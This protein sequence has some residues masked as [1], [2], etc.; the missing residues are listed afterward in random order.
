MPIILIV[1][2][3]GDV[4]Q[5]AVK[6]Y[7][8]EKLY[9]KAGFKSHE[10]FQRHHT[11]NVKLNDI[12]YNVSL[13]GKTTGA[14]RSENKYD[15]PPPVDNLLFFS[16]CVLVNRTDAGE[17][18][19]ITCEE[20][21]QVYTKLFGGF[22]DLTV[23]HS[24]SDDEMDTEDEV[25]AIRNKTGE[26]PQLTK[27]GYIKDDFIADSD[28]DE[29]EV[30]VSSKRKPAKRASPAVASKKKSKKSEPVIEPQEQDEYVGCTN[31]LEEE[32]YV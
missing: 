22:F 23:A 28:E 29:K 1:E 10:G 25:D 31:E 7:D 3:N 13:Y 20:W 9:T 2:K 8:E 21:K 15:F 30:E 27:S 19:N 4:K 32:S 11:W 17:V 6:V 12:S 5:L 24:D 18:S 16:N 14:A 26:T